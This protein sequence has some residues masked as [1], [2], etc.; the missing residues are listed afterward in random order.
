MRYSKFDIAVIAS[1]VC[2]LL[3]SLGWYG[4]HIS[5]MQWRSMVVSVESAL[6]EVFTQAN[7]VAIQANGLTNKSVIDSLVIEPAFLSKLQFPV[8]G[9]GEI[10]PSFVARSNVFLS[11]QSVHVPSDEILCVVEMPDKSLHGINGGGICL[12]VSSEQFGNWPHRTLAD[13]DLKTPH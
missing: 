12:T 2:L 7:E 8:N 13:Q 5:E 10:F 1:F 6:K 11:I 4:H 9:H 3:V